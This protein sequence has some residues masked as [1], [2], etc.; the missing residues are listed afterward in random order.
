MKS[1][2]KISKL[3]LVVLIA[4]IPILIAS[5]AFAFNIAT[6]HKIVNNTTQKEQI[7]TP[8]KTNEQVTDKS[9][10]VNVEP[11]DRKA[12][13]ESTS[14]TSAQ[15]VIQAPKT[16][17]TQSTLTGTEPTPQQTTAPAPTAPVC[18]ESMKTSYMSLYSSQVAS[19]NTSW[20]NQINAWNSYASAHGMAF[21]GYVQDQINQ[22]KPAHDARL[23]QIQT[24]YYQNLVSINCNL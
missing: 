15:A 8:E 4:A 2:F 17:N 1:L 6:P 24:Q 9:K 19:E 21:S 18:N 7:S 10:Q 20:N 12:V 3:K 16:T 5:T 11:A 14:K 22:N 23:A 13:S